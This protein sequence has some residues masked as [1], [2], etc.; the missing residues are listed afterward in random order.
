MHSVTQNVLAIGELDNNPYSDQE[1]QRLIAN[2]TQPRL[3]I[4]PSPNLAAGE[5]PAVVSE[6]GIPAADIQATAAA[7]VMMAT[8]TATAASGL[9]PGQASTTRRPRGAA[10]PTGS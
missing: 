1:V 5:A 7:A 2:L 4:Q 8:A 6:V 9:G 10:P 3:P